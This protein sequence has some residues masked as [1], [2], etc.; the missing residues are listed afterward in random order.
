MT[1]RKA[2][3]GA[4]YSVAR[5]QFES[6]PISDGVW[7]EA[8]LS[9]CFEVGTRCNLACCFC[10]SDSSPSG[11]STGTWIPNALKDWGAFAGPTRVVWSGGEPTLLAELPDLLEESS[12][13]GNI[14]VV[15][16]NGIRRRALDAAH[17]LDF[18]IY[19]ADNAQYRRATT[20]PVADRVWHNLEDA[21]G[22][23]RRVSANVILGIHGMQSLESILTRLLRVGVQR[24]KFH[25]PLVLGRWSTPS[26]ASHLAHE[27]SL[28]RDLCAGPGLLATFPLTGSYEEMRRGYIVVKPPGKVVI[29]EDS[30]NVADKALLD[31][32]LQRSL[33]EHSTVFVPGAGRANRR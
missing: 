21:V 1:D 31:A 7:I 8:P 16:T 32:L 3:T 4:W 11:S 2:T 17:W 12:A 6:S 30:A 26:E 28:A 14:N 20:R 5:D 22:T 15:A 23:G 13:Y 33:V 24:L 25:L 18:S 29:D 9:V 27:W 19:G 10:L